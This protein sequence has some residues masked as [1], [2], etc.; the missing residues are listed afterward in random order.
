MSINRVSLSGNL[1]RDIELRTT[2]SGMAIGTFSVAVNERKKQG[3]EWVDYPNYIDCKLFGRRAETL[4]QY[5]MKGTKVAISGRLHQDRWESDGQRRSRIEVNV[6]EVDIFRPKAQQAPPN[7]REYS[8][9]E[10]SVYDDDI[11]F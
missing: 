8:A 9:P 4:A 7:P 5:L 1:T 3:D 11:P 2:Q 10:V 6:D